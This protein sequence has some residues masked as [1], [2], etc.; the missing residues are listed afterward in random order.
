MRDAVDCELDHRALAPA[1]IV[2]FAGKNDPPFA[3]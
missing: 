1:A 2:D 3:D